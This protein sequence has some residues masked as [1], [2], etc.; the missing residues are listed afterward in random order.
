MCMI[1]PTM[2]LGLD[3]GDDQRTRQHAGYKPKTTAALQDIEDEEKEMMFEV[4]SEKLANAFSLMATEPGADIRII[5]NLRVCLDCHTATKF[6]SKVT[7]RLI[8]VRDAKRF[9]HFKDGGF[10]CGDC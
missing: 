3:M 9:H 1:C 4:H 2:Y 8:V 10:A 5:K 6:I 7:Y